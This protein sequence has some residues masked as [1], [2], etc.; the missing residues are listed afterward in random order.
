MSQTKLTI[1]DFIKGVDNS[2]QSFVKEID[3]YL[4][5]NNCKATFE[6]KKSGLLASYKYNNK[7]LINFL[8]RKR[9][10]LVRIYGE[11]VN[12][13]EELLTNLPDT[14]VEEIRS[15]SIC[16]RIVHNTCSPKCM[17]YDF[18]IKGEHFQKCRY[19]C[20]EFLVTGESS[21]YIKE[22]IKSELNQRIGHK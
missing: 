12:Q 10:L 19:N 9:G 8:F 11:N 18:K 22:L 13:N 20:F 5:E 2:Y 6:E 7:A 16:K 21:S 14:M 15:S 17:G 3:D 1:K 4:I